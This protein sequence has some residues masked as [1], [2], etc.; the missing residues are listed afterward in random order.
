M[1]ALSVLTPIHNC[2][3]FVHRC[4]AMLREQTFTDWEWV[5]IDDGSTDRTAELVAAIKD[6]RIRL[7][8]LPE[9]RGCG[10][11]RMRGIEACLGEWMVVWD[12]DDLYFPD[13][14]EKMNQARSEG[15]DYAASYAVV[16]SNDLKVKSVRGFMPF[17][18]FRKALVFVHP[19]MAC[20][21]DLAR[22]IAYD[23][24][25]WGSDFTIMLTLS[26]RHNGRLYEDALTL[27]QEERLIYLRKAIVGN[28]SHWK[29]TRRLYAKG[30]LPMGLLEYLAM[31][32]KWAAKLAV[33]NMMRLYPDSYNWSI[34]LRTQGRTD[35]DFALAPERWSFI[36][37]LAT[38]DFDKEATGR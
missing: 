38:R 12:A 5:V 34:G 25:E 11:T 33:L 19:T 18:H 15:Y 13:R 2:E 3:R 22:E 24:L 14:L 1:P 7:I 28:R 21:M 29:Q 10:Y 35:P 20:R 36:Q 23:D 32:V 26:A 17:K 6:D 4:Y 31:N 16:V 8:R 9:H 27:Y 37:R 30:V